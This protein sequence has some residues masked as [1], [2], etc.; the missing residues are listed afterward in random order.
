[1]TQNF[2]NVCNN[3]PHQKTA[4]AAVSHRLTRSL[5]L[6]SCSLS[7]KN[8]ILINW[9]KLNDLTFNAHRANGA[10][11]CFTLVS[12]VLLFVLTNKFY[13]NSCQEIWA[14]DECRVSK[15][16]CTI[17][18][19]K[20]EPLRQTGIKGKLCSVGRL[21]VVSYGMLHARYCFPTS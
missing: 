5:P 16:R 9:Y 19:W 8:R 21:T 12:I 4:Y 18:Q 10:F 17:I 7:L 2:I 13:A 15:C 20:Q 14:Y 1:M 6:L 11:I 3:L